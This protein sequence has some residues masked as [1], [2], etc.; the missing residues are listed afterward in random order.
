MNPEKLEAIRNAHSG[1]LPNEDCEYLLLVAEAVRASR[2]ADRDHAGGLHGSCMADICVERHALLEEIDSLQSTF[3]IR[4][5]ADMR[6][7]KRWQKAHSDNPGAELIWPDHAD[8]VVWLMGETE[9]WKTIHREEVVKLTARVIHRWRHPTYGMGPGVARC[10]CY[11]EAL[12][13]ADTI[14][15]EAQK[16]AE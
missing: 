15:A 9:R 7:I 16:L 12:F 14:D 10:K 2:R 1:C 6:A 8:L 4:W 11:G 5:K 3:D 13:L